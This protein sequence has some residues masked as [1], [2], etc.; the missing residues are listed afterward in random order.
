[1]KLGVIQS[2]TEGIQLAWRLL[3][4]RGWASALNALLLAL[5]LGAAGFVWLAQSQIERAFSRDLQGI[6]AVVGAKGSPMQLILS[7]VL[8]IDVPAGNVPLSAV[9]ALRSKPQVKAIIPI[10]LGDNF[11]GFRI[12]GTTPAYMALYEAKL[13]QGTLF[14]KPMQAVVGAEVAAATGLALGQSFAGFHGLGLGGEAHDKKLYLTTGVLQGCG[15]VLDRLI[16]TPTE[17]VWRVHDAEH[18]A[19]ESDLLEIEKAMLGQREITSALIQYNTPL[20]AASFPRFVNQQTAMQAASPALEITRLLRM[21]GAGTAVLKGFAIVLL[22][23]AALSVWVAL[24]S[25]LRERRADWAT[26][27]L[28]G[29][30][31]AKLTGVLAAQSIMLALIAS[32]LAAALAVAAHAGAGALAKASGVV[33][34]ASTNAAS[35]W[36][37]QL[38]QLWWLPLLAVGVA[39]LATLGPAWRLYRVDAAELLASRR[40]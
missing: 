38:G 29:A 12:V 11:G 26:L 27:R 30:S 28:L 20:A 32:A 4:Q 8:H 16:L 3:A 15:C 40:L 17:S 13:A 33:A 2:G 21:L 1:M 31:R 22:A 37:S 24:L 14:A 36:L 9:E 5:G 35:A 18:A 6:D 19:D 10:S 34:G 7:S 23:V 39:L 25:N